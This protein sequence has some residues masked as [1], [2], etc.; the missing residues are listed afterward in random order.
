M[1]GIEFDLLERGGAP[2]LELIDDLDTPA[3]DADHAANADVPREEIR[4]ITAEVKKRSADAAAHVHWGATS[5]DVLDTAMVLQLGEALPPL[6]KDLGVIVEALAKLAKR[7]RT[8]AML[9]R[10]LLQPATPLAL[11]QKIAGWA[12]DIDRAKR[13]LE[14]SFAETQIVQFGGASGSLSALGKKAEPVMKLLAR[15]LKLAL[16]PGPWFTQRGERLRRS[17]AD[18]AAGGRARHFAD[19]AVE[20]GERRAVRPGA[21]VPRPCRKAQPGRRGAD[22]GRCQRAPHSWRHLPGMVQEHERAP[23]GW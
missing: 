19:D 17:R 11:G 4:D 5:Q 10:T 16:P 1:S 7:H 3:T 21:A 2:W 9:G 14:E 18:R 6:L 12:S 23:G 8:T 22:P 13:R 20:V 15:R